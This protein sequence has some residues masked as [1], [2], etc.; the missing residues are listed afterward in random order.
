MVKPMSAVASDEPVMQRSNDEA[1]DLKLEVVVL[2]VADVDRTKAFYG[3]LGWR[4][5]GDFKKGADWR[6]V[7]MTPPGSA[8]SIHFGTGLTPSAPG[9][10][11][12]RQ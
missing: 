6:L 10:P 3:S 11:P 8:C 5:H 9:L 2:P 4:L 1:I 7:Q 12:V